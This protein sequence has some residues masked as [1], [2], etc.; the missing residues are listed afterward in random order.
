VVLDVLREGIDAVRAEEATILEATQ[1]V[2]LHH[3]GS[4]EE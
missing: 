3:I 1:L 2:D 4:R